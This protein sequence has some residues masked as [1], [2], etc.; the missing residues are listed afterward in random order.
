[1]TLGQAI[2]KSRRLA[3]VDVTGK[4]DSE[5][6]DCVNESMKAFAKRTR[7]LIKS[8]YLDIVPRFDVNENMAINLTITGGTN[9]IAATDIVITAADALGISGTTLASY[10]QA[11]IRAAIGGGAN[12]TVSWS[13]TAWLFTIDSVDGTEI[14]VSDPSAIIYSDAT[15]LIGISGTKTASSFQGNF[16]TDCTVISDLPSDFVGLKTSPEWDGDELY[17]SPANIFTSPEVFGEPTRYYVMGDTMK[18]YPSPN[19]QGKLHIIYKYF[20]TEFERVSGYQECGLTGK[21]NTTSTGLSASTQY[22]FKLS[23]NGAPVVEYD[24]TTGTDTSYY[25]VI[26]LMNA[27]ISGAVFSIVNGDL[28][29]TSSLEGENS[30]VSLSSGTTGTDLF[31]TLTDFDALETALLPEYTTDIPIDDDYCIAIVFHTAAQLLEESFETKLSD[32]NYAQFELK[33]S[34]Y[35]VERG[36]QNTSIFPLRVYRNLWRT[37]PDANS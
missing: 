37:D 15:G 6:M 31:A 8:A 13:T 2:S 20:P 9:A 5:I 14:T 27:E 21:T 28:R 7:H 3:R 4:L 16:P 22:Y 32:R 10:L 29:C 1:M 33:C 24:I 19:R 34:E 11:Q 17:E 18:L 36:N 26:A 25:S 35:N 12:L 30:S 23:L